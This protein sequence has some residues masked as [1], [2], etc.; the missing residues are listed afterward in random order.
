ML[1]LKVRPLI[2]L[3]IIQKEN[4]FRIPFIEEKGAPSMVLLNKV[5]LFEV[6]D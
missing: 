3:Y 1:H 6:F 5:H 2:L 4:D